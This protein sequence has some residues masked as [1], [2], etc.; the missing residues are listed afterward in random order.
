MAISDSTIFTVAHDLHRAR[1]QPLSPF[2]SKTKVASQTSI[3]QGHLEK[4][5][6]RLT[7][8]TKSGAAFNFGAAITAFARDSSTNFILGESYN[9]L[10]REDFE[11][12]LLTVTHG[13]G[14][15]WHITK[16]IRWVM[17]AVKKIPVPL[18]MRIG[19]E[20]VKTMFRTIQVGGC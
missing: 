14:K 5:C 2:F 4:L 15:I 3:I 6:D 11:V 10:D 12:A 8:F 7:G 1:R 13:S 17:P 9:T 16:F 20:D 19:S 18:M